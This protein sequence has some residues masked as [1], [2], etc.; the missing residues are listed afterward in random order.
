MMPLC[1]LVLFVRFVAWPVGLR[2]IDALDAED[3]IT[4]DGVVAQ[5]SQ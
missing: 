2:L 3:E 5:R 1:A 4:G